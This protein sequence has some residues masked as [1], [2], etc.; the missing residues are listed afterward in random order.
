MSYEFGLTRTVRDAAHLL[1]AVQ[2]SGVGD[3][4][5]APPPSRPY[6]EERAPT[7]VPC[8]WR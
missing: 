6:V 7:Q 5:M 8:G 4:Y 2:G 3:K 1:D